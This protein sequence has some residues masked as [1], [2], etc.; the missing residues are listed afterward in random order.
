VVADAELLTE[1][2][3]S[4]V[5]VEVARFEEVVDV[6]VFGLDLIF[7]VLNCSLPS[8]VR[9]VITAGTVEVVVV[10]VIVVG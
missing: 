10:V 4:M 2:A 6:M 3:V 8:V 1:I 5:V 9:E 7:F